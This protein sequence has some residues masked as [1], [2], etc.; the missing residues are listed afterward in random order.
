MKIDELMTRGVESC[1]P[2]DSLSRAAQIMWERDCGCVPVV[3]EDG[4]LA[5]I[6]TDRDICMAAF[7]KGKRL[8]EI[9][10]EEVMTR[11]VQFCTTADSFETAASLMQLHQVRRLPVVR[12]D[13]SVVGIVSLNDLF[14]GGQREA[15]PRI[16]QKQAIALEQARVAVCRPRTA[17]RAPAERPM[18]NEAS[19]RSLMAKP[20]SSTS[21]S[22]S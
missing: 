13:G 8:D 6:V 4:T 22:G 5:G 19:M 10:A 14:T 9:S 16:K 15:D 12:S 20:R 7:T 3:F 17:A 11:S 2:R 1:G 18:A 21:H